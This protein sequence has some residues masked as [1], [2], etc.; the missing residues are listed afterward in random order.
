MWLHESSETSLVRCS[1]IELYDTSKRDLKFKHVICA[2]IEFETKVM[3]G[4]V[5]TLVCNVYCLVS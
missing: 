5:K 2:Q 3:Q 1:Y 4:K